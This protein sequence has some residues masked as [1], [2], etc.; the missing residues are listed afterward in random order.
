M[1]NFVGSI[2]ILAMIAPLPAAYAQVPVEP[3]TRSMPAPS[4]EEQSP[5]TLMPISEW[6]LQQQE[7]GCALR[8]SF[9][10]PDLPTVI[11]FRRNEPKSGGFDIAI[12]SEEFAMND[13][14]FVATLL[15]GG[16]EY[17]PPLPGR[18]QE[19][20]GALWTV[21]AHY[22]GLAS[23]RNFTSE[24]W[25]RYRAD[26][27][28]EKFRRSVE[29]LKITGLFD[30]D[31]ELVTGAVSEP[32]QMLTDCY[33]QVMIAHGMTREDALEDNRPVDFKN[34]VRILGSMA[35][36]LPQAL[37]ARIERGKQVRVNFAVFLN[38]NA[39]PTGCRLT[40]VPRYRELE[41]Q[42]CERIIREGRFEFKTGE[43]RRPAMV[44]AGYLFLPDRGFHFTGG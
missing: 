7:H 15:P 44:Q 23:R 36:L 42:G 22:I 30:R 27:G 14:P 3:M 5:V 16:V 31:I 11:E 26:D 41:T 35:Y 20:S 28:P 32:R 9:G 10:S 1:R 34:R 4:I 40:T 2:S 6:S 8:R 33:D 12:S 19:A 39:E 37:M 43:D 13:G 21:W 17:A 38:V 24:E 18:E 29:S 25:D